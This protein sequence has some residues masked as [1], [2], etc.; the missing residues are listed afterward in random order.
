M[1]PTAVQNVG[2][3][4]DLFIQAQADELVRSARRDLVERIHDRLDERQDEHR[5]EEQQ[6]REDEQEPGAFPAIEVI[7][8][9]RDAKPLA[10]GVDVARTAGA[11]ASGYQRCFMGGAAED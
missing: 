3:G 1:F 7:P 2:V 6:R 11:R 8:G 4:Q 9:K 5:T 10:H